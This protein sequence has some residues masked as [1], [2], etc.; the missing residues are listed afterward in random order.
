VSKTVKLLIGLGLGLPLVMCLGLR[1]IYETTKTEDPR[2]AQRQANLVQELPLRFAQLGEK[3]DAEPR[4]ACP[5]WTRSEAL[6]GTVDR[7]FVDAL[8]GKASV[9][10]PMV[11]LRSPS[12]VKILEAVRSGRAK[13]TVDLAA[14]NGRLQEFEESGVIAVVDPVA[15]AWP[16]L[17][18]DGT[19][20]PGTAAGT[21]SLVDLRSE[22][23]LVLCK[24]LFKATNS[25]EVTLKKLAALGGAVL[26]QARLEADLT[27]QV[28]QEVSRLYQAMRAGEAWADRDQELASLVDAGL[29]QRAGPPRAPKPSGKNR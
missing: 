26:A 20:V 3:L 13:Q 4:G 18:T 15:L 2:V 22:G 14:L 5:D 12:L 21:L 23:D 1:V 19:F 11:A 24:A 10:P 9:R 25:E 17:M 16:R 28:E 29:R 8:A 7:A 6:M 27:S